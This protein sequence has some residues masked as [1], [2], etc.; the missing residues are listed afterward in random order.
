MKKEN[1]SCNYRKVPKIF[2]KIPTN[3]KEGRGYSSFK[4]Y[5]GARFREWRVGKGAFK[6]GG[7]NLIADAKRSART[8]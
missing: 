5:V 2:L 8:A 7:H 4:G 1:S 3:I 6:I